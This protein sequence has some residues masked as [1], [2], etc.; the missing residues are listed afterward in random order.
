[1]PLVIQAVKKHKRKNNFRLLRAA[2]R[3]PQTEATVD[4]CI[5]ELR[6]DYDLSDVRQEN[7]C[8]AVAFILY[9]AHSPCF[10]NAS[11]RFSP[12]PRSP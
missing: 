9:H 3:L 11:T 2:E 8:F 1:M 7:H 10:G 5:R 6:R 4:W 12:H